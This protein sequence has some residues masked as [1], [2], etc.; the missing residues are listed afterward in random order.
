MHTHT[1]CFSYS[2]LHEYVGYGDEVHST[3]RMRTLAI[4]YIPILVGVMSHFLGTV[5]RVITD[6]RKNSLL[7]H[8]QNREWKPS[9]WR[10]MDCDG[11]GIVT[12]ADFIVFMLSNMQEV[13]IRLLDRLRKHFRSLAHRDLHV[14]N[15]STTFPERTIPRVHLH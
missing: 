6:V 7:R 2:F 8:M 11:D 10:D 12:E 9:D 1:Q 15:N 3:K 14:S 13:D 4:L 5:A